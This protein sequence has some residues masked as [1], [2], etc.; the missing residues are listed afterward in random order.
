[1]NSI[2][3]FVPI[4]KHEAYIEE[5]LRSLDRQSRLPDQVFVLDDGSPDRSMIR[6]LT[7]PVNLPIEYLAQSNVGPAMALS[8]GMK[9]MRTDM[10]A[11]L[12]SDDFYHPN[13]LAVLEEVLLSSGAD[14]AFSGVDFV[15]GLGVPLNVEWYKASRDAFF[16]GSQHLPSSLAVGNW[17]VSTSNLIF[18]RSVLGKIDF[19]DFRFAQDLDF[20]LQAVSHNLRIAYAPQPLLYYRYHDSNTVRESQMLVDKDVF[21]VLSHH[22]TGEVGPLNEHDTRNYWRAL[23]DLHAGDNILLRMLMEAREMLAEP[24]NLQRLIQAWRSEK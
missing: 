16:G 2:G 13:R 9:M 6:A 5:C 24:V 4:Y 19:R 22:L 11:I 3:V 10:I 21:Q 7:T 14:I 23:R 12:N 1:M 8:I 18:H 20:M 15:D 17:L